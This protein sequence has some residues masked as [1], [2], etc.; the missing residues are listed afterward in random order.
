MTTRADHLRKYVIAALRNYVIVH[1]RPG[2]KP[3]TTRSA[4]RPACRSSPWEHDADNQHRR[5]SLHLCRSV[6]RRVIG[7]CCS[8][9]T[10]TARSRVGATWQNPV[11]CASEGFDLVERGAESVAFDFEVVACLEVDPE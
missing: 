5:C 3:V 10:A 7:L 8:R 1:T 6:D 2:L 9:R 11:L 4:L